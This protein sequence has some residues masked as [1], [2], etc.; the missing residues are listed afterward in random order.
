MET[1]HVTELAKA[2][3]DDTVQIPVRSE[4]TKTIVGTFSYPQG[5]WEREKRYAEENA[6]KPLPSFLC[7]KHDGSDGRVGRNMLFALD[8][9]AGHIECGEEWEMDDVDGFTPAPG[10]TPATREEI[11]DRMRAYWAVA[12]NPEQAN[13]S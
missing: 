4:A 11:G 6:L 12:N 13:K 7:I 8:Y 1:E 10:R 9:A 5:E 3:A 2:A